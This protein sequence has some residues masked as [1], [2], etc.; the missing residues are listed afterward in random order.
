M[1]EF[2]EGG[3]TMDCIYYY[4]YMGIT[5]TLATTTYML[6]EHEINT[7]NISSLISFTLEVNHSL[8]VLYGTITAFVRVI[9]VYPQSKTVCH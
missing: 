4:H 9:V 8:H 6:W 5:T 7:I 2:H 3:S 1:S